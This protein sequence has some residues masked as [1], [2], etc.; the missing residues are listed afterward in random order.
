MQQGKMMR[1]KKKKKMRETSAAPAPPPPTQQQQSNLLQRGKGSDESYPV[2]KF[3]NK[4]KNKSEKKRGMKLFK[5]LKKSKLRWND[6]GEIV[7]NYNPVRGSNIIVLLKHALRKTKSQPL[8]VKSFYKAL[9]HLYVPPDIVQNPMG[10]Q[11][12]KQRE[13]FRPPG[14]LVETVSTKTLP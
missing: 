14:E 2:M 13:P 5:M 6:K 1:W 3:I 4:F 12:V 9:K 11:L 8:G 7:V 10:Q